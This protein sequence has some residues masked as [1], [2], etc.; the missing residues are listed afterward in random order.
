M[1]VYSDEMRWLPLEGQENLSV[2]VLPRIVITRLAAV[3]LLRC[4]VCSVN[5]GFCSLFVLFFLIG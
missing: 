2:R 4:D 1:T 5:D 3:R